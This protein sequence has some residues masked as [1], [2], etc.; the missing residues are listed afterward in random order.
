MTPVAGRAVVAVVAIIA[1]ATIVGLS[2]FYRDTG[3][4]V[5]I[6]REKGITMTFDESEIDLPDLLLDLLAEDGSS[7]N[8][9]QMVEAV[10]ERQGYYHMSNLRLADALRTLS[11]DDPNGL[12]AALRELLYDLDGPFAP[13][14][15]LAGATDD[16]LLREALAALEVDLD[17]I[18]ALTPEAVN[19]LLASL[20][21]QSLERDGVL[22]ARPIQAVL[23]P[24]GNIEP[25]R[26]FACDL[27]MLDNKEVTI[28]GQGGRL[29]V[30]ANVFCDPPAPQPRELLGGA[31]ERLWVSR[32]DFAVL[33]GGE[34]RGSMDVRLNPS[35]RAFRAFVPEPPGAATQP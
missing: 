8:H 2:I 33:A 14:H 28:V 35:P 3:F 26:A 11:A 23:R 4:E 30:E 31:V 21:E 25:G 22:K 34:Q 7:G 16:R 17:K 20:W 24:A 6:D 9:R 10:L 1:L 5:V 12:A 13:P 27:S 15:T 29:L 32:E 19:P 18:A